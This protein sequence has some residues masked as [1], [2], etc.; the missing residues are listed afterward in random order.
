M[1]PCV[2][3]ALQYDERIWK[4]GYMIRRVIE[5]DQ[6]AC[7]G[8]GLC[9]SA[10]HEGAIALI[11]GKAQ[12]VRDDYCDGLGDCLPACP[13]DAISFVEREAA[14]YDEAAVQAH[15]ERQGSPVKRAAFNAKVGEMAAETTKISS[16][17]GDLDRYF[18]GENNVRRPAN[19]TG[20]LPIIGDAGTVRPQSE[21]T[22]WP[23]QIKLAPVKAS[24]FDGANLLIAADCTAF[25][26]GDFHHEFM[27][28]KITLIGCPKLDGVNYAEKL[29]EILANNNIASVTVVR[30][31]VPCCKG[32]ELAAHEAI[33]LSGKPLDLSVH[34]V[35]TQG[36]LV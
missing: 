19:P 18:P 35:S 11:N 33:R 24:Y 7:I 1:K 9:V 27:K 31:V 13:V 17:S 34:I 28:D 25:A 3:V 30:M 10:C 12:L 32:L 21:L 6:D 14:A 36:Q 16:S 23:I 4:R 5:I 26:Y 29:S 20:K 2:F 8:C 15:L 22:Q